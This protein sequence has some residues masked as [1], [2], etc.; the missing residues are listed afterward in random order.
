M[1][2]RTGMRWP[3]PLKSR[4]GID[5]EFGS[6]GIVAVGNAV[7]AALDMAAQ[8]RP[9]AQQENPGL[10]AETDGRH[11]GSLEKTCHPVGIAVDQRHNL[12]A[13]RGVLTPLEGEVG[14]EPVD[15]RA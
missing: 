14:D 3:D 6:A 12:G 1:W 13:D 7:G 8:F 10:L 15:R 4:I 2:M 9:A 5:E 11:L